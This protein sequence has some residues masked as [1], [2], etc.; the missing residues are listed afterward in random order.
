MA[1]DDIRDFERET[2]HGRFR[3][4]AM[5]LENGLLVL[6]SDSE[7]Y[8]LGLSALAIPASPGHVEPTSTGFLSVGEDAVQVR[9]LAESVARRTGRTCMLVVAMKELNRTTMME[10]TKAL[11]EYLPK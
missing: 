2:E 1:F 9:I 8:R 4:R 11:R 7:R 3:V 10:I 6:I 5:D